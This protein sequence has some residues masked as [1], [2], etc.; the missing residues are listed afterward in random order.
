M[1]VG[2]GLQVALTSIIGRGAGFTQLQVG[3]A[4]LGRDAIL[5]KPESGTLIG[6]VKVGKD[7]R[8]G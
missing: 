2:R 8:V 4:L 1:R 3:N 6:G 5:G 7:S